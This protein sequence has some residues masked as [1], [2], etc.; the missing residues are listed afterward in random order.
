MDDECCGPSLA[1]DGRAAVA[2]RFTALGAGHSLREIWHQLPTRDRPSPP[3]RASV[4]PTKEA[5]LAGRTF[6]RPPAPQDCRKAV[7][8]PSWLAAW[9]TFNGQWVGQPAR[10]GQLKGETVAG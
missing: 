4:R 6:I 10:A 5:A 8:I 3:V 2:K 1:S 7:Y 9:Y